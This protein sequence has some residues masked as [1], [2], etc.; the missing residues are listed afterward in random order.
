MPK[1]PRKALEMRQRQLGVPQPA[2]DA[3]RTT[4]GHARDSL[5]PSPPPLALP[6]LHYQA[7][8]P[9]HTARL[10]LPNLPF[11]LPALT[12]GASR[13][14]PAAVSLAALAPFPGRSP[15]SPRSRAGE[16]G[17][18]AKA[19]GGARGREEPGRGGP[20]LIIPGARDLPGPRAA[21]LQWSLRLGRGG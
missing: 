1:L 17:G 2:T 15:V 10:P 9:F 21:A 16:R 14:H 3:S 11:P 4:A 5:A 18:A 19:R 13:R 12:Q 20:G 8:L 6:S 7:P